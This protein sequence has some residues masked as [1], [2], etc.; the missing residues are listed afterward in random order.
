MFDV[1]AVVPLTHVVP[2]RR[3]A[4]T[5]CWGADFYPPFFAG[6]TPNSFLPQ[7]ELAG[8][9]VSLHNQKLALESVVKELQDTKQTVDRF[10]YQRFIV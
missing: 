9:D 3:C 1:L 10:R 8:R 4:R 6:A 2:G 5:V 7:G